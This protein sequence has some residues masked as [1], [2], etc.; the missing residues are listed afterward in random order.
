[1]SRTQPTNDGMINI[2]IDQN[3][4]MLLSGLSGHYQTAGDGAVIGRSIN[5]LVVSK[6]DCK[7]PSSMTDSRDRLSSEGWRGTERG[8]ERR[9]G[10]IGRA[11][12]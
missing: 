2:L 10:E 4:W 9:R 12:V 6:E 1:M 5:Q 7:W 3:K 11:H 8:G